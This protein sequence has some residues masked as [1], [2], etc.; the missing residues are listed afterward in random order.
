MP[1]IFVLSLPEAYT[2]NFLLMTDSY[3]K[4]IYQMDLATGDVRAIPVLTD[5]DNPIAV[6]YDPQTS[7]VY[8][9]DV[10]SKDI[11][12]ARLDGSDDSLV[13]TLNSGPYHSYLIVLFL[14]WI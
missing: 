4:E 10:S 8:W 1:N 13:R 3:R 11:R 12:S 14:S 6:D 2:D 5:H 7:T 9:T